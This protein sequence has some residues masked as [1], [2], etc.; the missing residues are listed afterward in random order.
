MSESGIKINKS[1]LQESMRAMDFSAPPALNQEE[2]KYSAYY[3]LGFE[4]KLPGIQHG[5]GYLL[6]EKQKIA[7]HSYQLKQSSGT[8]FICH[9]Y[10]DHVGLY[11]HIIEKTLKLGFNVIAWDLQGHGLSMGEPG[12][13][14]S[15]NTYVESL[16]TILNNAENKLPHP[17]HIV[18]QSTGGAIV[19]DY[20]LSLGNNNYPFETTTL[21]APLYLPQEWSKGK[22]KYHIVKFFLRF[23]KRDNNTSSHDNKFVEF[24]RQDPLRINNLSVQWV[25][26]LIRWQKIIKA[27]QQSL[28]KIAVIQGQQDNTVDWKKNI[29][30]IK[31]KFPNSEMHFIPEAKHHLVNESI[32]IR[33]KVFTALENILT[34]SKKQ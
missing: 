23:A 29:K 27:K 34:E 10:F 8:V 22:F 32:E 33:E 12:V 17:W 3:Q 16:R 25:G 4:K 5:F 19:M 26:S 20:L 9:G 21:L 18:A 6:V 7:V 13:V 24:V 1:S 31:E 30:F 14:D 28:E 15:F 2:S 11:S